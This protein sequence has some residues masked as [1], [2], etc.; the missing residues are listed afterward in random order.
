M[1]RRSDRIGD[2]VTHRVYRFD[3]HIHV[4]IG[5]RLHLGLRTAA[6]RGRRPYLYF[7]YHQ[8]IFIIVTDLLLPI[9][10]DGF[11][12]AAKAIVYILR[13]QRLIAAGNGFCRR[14]VAC[15]IGIRGGHRDARA[16]FGSGQQA[17]VF[18]IGIGRR[19][20]IPIRLR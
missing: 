2:A 3:E 7:G 17:T 9:R 4:V 5:I 1:R 13:G 14:V 19:F 20:P 16:C 12:Q 15:V 6:V 8:P 18:I 10:I 11:E